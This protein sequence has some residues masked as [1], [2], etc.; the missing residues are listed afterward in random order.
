YIELDIKVKH[1]PQRHI[2]GA[3]IEVLK[4]ANDFGDN[5]LVLVCCDSVEPVKN[6]TFCRI[7][8]VSVFDDPTK[9]LFSFVSS[10]GCRLD[11][12]RKEVDMMESDYSATVF[13]V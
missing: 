11:S 13:D 10:Q 1:W 4:L 12:A 9:G 7:I 6:S 3:Q 2:L 8:R 5:P